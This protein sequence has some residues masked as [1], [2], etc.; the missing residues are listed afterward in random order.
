MVRRP[1]NSPDSARFGC[2]TSFA[3]PRFD[4][5]PTWSEFDEFGARLAEIALTLLPGV[6]FWPMMEVISKVL[7]GGHSPAKPAFLCRAHRFATE[8]D[9]MFDTRVLATSVS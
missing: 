9:E 3:Q 6:M 7:S 4:L 5:G 1:A 8:I 2:W